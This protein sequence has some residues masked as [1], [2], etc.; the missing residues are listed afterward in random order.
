MTTNESLTDVSPRARE[1]LFRVWVSRGEIRY[2]DIKW[3]LARRLEH[4]TPVCACFR[5]AGYPDAA[6]APTTGQYRFLE[7][8][9]AEAE[10]DG[11]VEV[12]P[13]WARDERDRWIPVDDFKGKDIE[14]RKTYLPPGGVP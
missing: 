12:D 11:R 5:L 10:L 7:A 14:Y 1:I 2:A 13:L 9:R 4:E 8:L 6:V 3:L